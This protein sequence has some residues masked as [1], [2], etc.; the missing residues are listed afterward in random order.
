MSLSLT[1]DALL[2]QMIGGQLKRFAN[3]RKDLLVAVNEVVSLLYLNCIDIQ[4]SLLMNSAAAY[5]I[6]ISKICLK[7]ISSRSC[8]GFFTH[9]D[10]KTLN[11]A[12]RNFLVKIYWMSSL[13]PIFDLFPSSNAI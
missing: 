5:S 3:A 9:K 8:I 13:C 12:L 7:L 1:L 10:N 4:S 2:F 6:F 11:P